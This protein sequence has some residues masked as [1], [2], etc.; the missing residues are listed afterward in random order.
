[1]KRTISIILCLA[2]VCALLALPAA[3]APTDP[4]AVK[5]Q[6]FLNKCDSLYKGDV[7]EL[8]IADTMKAFAAQENQES[9]EATAFETEIAKHIVLSD[10][11]L[12]ELR[13]TERG[14]YDSV[15]NTYK[16]QH[17]EDK[18]PDTVKRQYRGYVKT[19]ENTYDVYYQEF[20][21]DP[22]ENTEIISQ[23]K[24]P[25]TGN[26]EYNGKVYVRD[27]DGY[28]CVKNWGE[29][30]NKY[31]IEV[32][33]DAKI[34]FICGESYG[35]DQQ[36]ETFDDV[37]VTYDLPKD[38][39]VYLDDLAY[40]P[41]Q[42]VVKVERIT[43]VVEEIAQAMT[44]VSTRYAPYSFTATQNGNP[45]QPKSKMKVHFVVPENFGADTVVMHL[46]AEGKLTELASMVKNIEG[47][48]YLM[49]ELEHFSTY[50]LVDKDAK[51]AEPTT[52]PT[53][54]P[55]TEATTVPTTAATQATVEQTKQTNAATQPTET[56]ATAA[57]KETSAATKATA[58]PGSKPTSVTVAKPT[59]VVPT[60]EVVSDPTKGTAADPSKGTAAPTEET[61]VDPTGETAV[62]PTEETAPTGETAVAP[63]E[64]SKPAKSNKTG[65]IIAAVIIVVALAGGGFAAW[66]FYFRKK[67]V[68]EETEE[69]EKTEE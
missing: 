43:G 58:A 7:M 1:M 6:E 67:T 34:R 55:T 63:T 31:S 17:P 18:E 15:T 9:V 11:V 10:T 4:L 23:Y 2:C 24:N 35:A 20:D 60:W 48:S 37:S 3:A 66:W 46:D 42:T 41:D 8:V 59:V 32:S 52:E 13:S 64:A 16:L 21:R 57:T 14:L 29:S 65:G 33:E 27:S 44:T 5:F 62:A 22:L 39:T 40:F 36:P 38:D 51:P 30:G 54:A 53:V 25:I 68:A 61:A 26:V 45:V 19:G 50:V 47:T 56:K 49:T 69:T 28:Y 12:N